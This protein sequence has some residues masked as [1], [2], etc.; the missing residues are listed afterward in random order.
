MNTNSA[1]AFA[2]QPLNLTPADSSPLSVAPQLAFVSRSS[3]LL[4]VDSSVSDYKALV[5]GSAPGTEVH[6]LNSNENAVTQITNTLLG[7]GGISSLHIVSHGEAGGLD[8]GSNA[9]NLTDLP[10]Y[11][12]QLKT[13]SKA[14][15]NDADILL[16][17]CT[18]AAGEVGQM[19][20]KNISQLTGADIAASNNLTGKDGDW[21]LEVT[22]GNIESSLVFDSSVT[23]AYAYDLNILGETFKG[24]DVTNPSWIYNTTGTQPS[25]TARSTPAA[26]TGGIPGGGSDAVGSGALRLTHILHQSQ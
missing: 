12:A 17:G 9:L 2:Q 18:V 23:A 16:Y 7:R 21:N 10:Q 25:L 1:S 22:T 8:F 20:V 13:W 4:F 3:S 19:F 15:T 6:V 14:L 24:N 26:S 11:A 5:A